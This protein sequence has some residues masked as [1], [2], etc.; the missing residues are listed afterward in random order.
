MEHAQLGSQ[1]SWDTSLSVNNP[2]IDSANQRTFKILSSLFL[3]IK[4]GDKSEETQYLLEKLI[5]HIRML[6]ILEERLMSREYYPD[7]MLHESEHI[8]MLDLLLNFHKGLKIGEDIDDQDIQCIFDWFVV[9]T[10]GAG[11][12]FMSFTSKEEIE[13]LKQGGARSPRMDEMEKNSAKISSAPNYYDIYQ[14]QN[15]LTAPF[16][17]VLCIAVMLSVALAVAYLFVIE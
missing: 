7:L 12:K 11:K 13:S 15:R 5:V 8:S 16:I 9:H 1:F 14:I 6:F 17:I 4:T 2:E 3:S 10:I